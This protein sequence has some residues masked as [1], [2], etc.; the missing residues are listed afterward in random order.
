MERRNDDHRDRAR[1]LRRNGTMPEK[2]LW[3]MLR[4]RRLASLKFRR[5]MPV[6]NYIVD[7]A[8]VEHRLVVESMAIAMMVGMLRIPPESG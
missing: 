5:Q 6:G 1:E 7:F 2:L 3:G 8:C 4:G